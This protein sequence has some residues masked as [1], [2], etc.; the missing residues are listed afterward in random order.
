MI[1]DQ[2]IGAYLDSHF[3]TVAGSRQGKGRNV[4]IPNL[5]LYSG[6]VLVTDPK[7]ELANVTAKRRAEGLGQ[8]V[9]VLDPFA[10]TS[11]RVASLSRS[12]E[13]DGRTRSQ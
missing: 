9:C 13:S 2:P 1:G 10:I 5:L 4:I 6:S 3:M 11:N 7:G 12:L 8:R